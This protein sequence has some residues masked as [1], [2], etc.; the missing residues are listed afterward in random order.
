MNVPLSITSSA[1]RLG[2][3]AVVAAG[4]DVAVRGAVCDMEILGSWKLR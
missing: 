1:I 3:S 4:A 2:R